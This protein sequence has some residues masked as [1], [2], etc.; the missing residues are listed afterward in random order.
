MPKPTT[1]KVKN[2]SAKP[3]PAKKAKVAK[4]K[5]ARPPPSSSSGSG[6]GSDSESG[7]GDDRA[8]MLAALEAHTRSLFGLDVAESSAQGA[9]RSVSESESESGSAEEAEEEDYDDEFDDGWGEGDAFV[10]DSEDEMDFDAMMN[11]AKKAKAKKGKGKAKEKEAAAP[12]SAPTAIAPSPAP[13]EVV[14]A[15]TGRPA[16]AISSSEKRAFLKGNSA[17]IMGLQPEE[18]TGQGKRKRK[19]EDEEEESNQR[20]DKTLHNMLLTSLL[21]AATQDAAS[22]PVDKRAAMSG[23]LLE[24][25]SYSLPGEGEGTVRGASLSSHPAKVRTGLVHAQQRRAESARAE[26]EAAGSW[27]K[28]KGGLGDLGRRGAGS[29]GKER[30]VR[31][32]GTTSKKKGMEAGKKERAMGLGMGVGTY[33]KGA[34]RIDEGTI[35]RINGGKGRGGKGGGKKGKGKRGW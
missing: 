21:P 20:L 34:L 2:V 5:V 29:K 16:M 7:E 26:A 31:T 17:K 30:E 15:E 14:F 25:A 27:V 10:T 6:S 3:T 9:A 28:G 8:A 19:A 1:A 22:R 11:N 24:L 4:G 18:Q 35:A 33:D 32:F 13:V 12:K 23:R